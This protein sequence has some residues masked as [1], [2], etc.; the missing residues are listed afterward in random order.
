MFRRVTLLWIL[1][2]T[3]A[4]AGCTTDQRRRVESYLLTRAASGMQTSA[5]QFPTLIISQGQTRLP[6]G[7]TQAA[8][9]LTPAR[10]ST[11]YQIHTEDVILFNVNK[12][13]KAREAAYRFSTPADYLVQQNRTQYPSITGPESELSPG[14]VILIFL[15]TP[16]RPDLIPYD[17]QAWKSLHRCGT[18]APGETT[19]ADV[20]LDFISEKGRNLECLPSTPT[21]EYLVH[22]RYQGPVLYRNG[23]PFVYGVYWD[24]AQNTVLLGP[25]VIDLKSD[26]Q[27]CGF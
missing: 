21:G 25:A 6:Q 3:I 16:G 19:C 2:L 1:I 20:T 26:V 22:S 27:Q 10:P 23:L 5:V 9:A 12:P 4:L 15:G 7:L 24:A 18:N 17:P 8:G 11:G 14:W 13:I